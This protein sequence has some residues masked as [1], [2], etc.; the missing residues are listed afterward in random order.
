MT[1]PVLSRLFAAGVDVFAHEWTFP[2]WPYIQPVE[3]ITADMLETR[4]AQNSSRRVQARRGRDWDVVSQEI[5]EDNV[6]IL[7]QAMEA[8]AVLQQEFD[9]TID[10]REVLSLP[11]PDQVSLNLTSDRMQSN[12]PTAQ[13][14]L[15]TQ[16]QE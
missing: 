6:L 14:A 1:D 9:Q 5:I 8:A 12:E 7:R 2:S 15:G 11:T 4:N 10:W 16:S 3:D 13:T